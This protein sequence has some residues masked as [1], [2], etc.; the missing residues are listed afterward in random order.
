MPFSSGIDVMSQKRSEARIASCIQA[1]IFDLD[2][3]VELKCIIRDV[4]PSGCM[5]VSSRIH[6]LPELVNIVPQGFP[7]PIRATIMWR[8]GKTAGLYVRPQLLEKVIWCDYDEDANGVLILTPTRKPIN[9]SDRLDRSR[10]LEMEQ[11]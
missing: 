6:E 11:L 5:I 10:H 9:Y 4:S 8:K 7:N 1:F 2:D 3:S